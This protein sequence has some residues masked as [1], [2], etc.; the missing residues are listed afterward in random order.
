MHDGNRGGGVTEA[1]NAEEDR[2]AAYD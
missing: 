2:Q 1:N